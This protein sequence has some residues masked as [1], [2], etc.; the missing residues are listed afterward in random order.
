MNETGR[1]VEESCRGV[2]VFMPTGNTL[3]WGYALRENTV[4]FL[5]RLKDFVWRIQKLTVMASTKNAGRAERRE[6]L[7]WI[8]T[9]DSKFTQ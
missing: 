3:M 7:R 8:G 2:N 1:G 5:R 9:A 6:E 4:C